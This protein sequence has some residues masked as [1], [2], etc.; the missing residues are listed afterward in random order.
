M[1]ASQGRQTDPGTYL[2][3]TLSILCPWRRSVRDVADLARP[4]NRSQNNNVTTK[5]HD[6]KQESAIVAGREIR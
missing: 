6:P 5:E 3:S 1:A 2:D 4:R